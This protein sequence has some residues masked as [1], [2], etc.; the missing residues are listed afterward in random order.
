MMKKM[1]GISRVLLILS[2][3]LVVC[4]IFF[5]WWGMEFFAPQYPEGLNII[6]YPNHME[7]NLDAINSLNHYIGMKEF[8]DENFPELGYL[9]YL[10]VGLA[11]LTLAVAAIGRR[12]YLFVLAV[13]FSFGGALGLYD[14]HRWLYHFCTDLDPKAPI[15]VPP[16]VA[17]M[18]GDNK[19]ANFIT[20]SY[21]TTG[22]FLLGAA[23]LLVAVAIWRER[24]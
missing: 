24:K 13:M 20:H 10:I 8:S 11:A 5:P 7:G 12:V 23:F 3:A 17:P 16:F 4:T 9:T 2:A 15:K 19:L 21:F 1:S 14:I 6:V 22:S 18:I